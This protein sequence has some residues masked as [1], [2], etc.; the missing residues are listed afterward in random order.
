MHQPRFC[1]CSRRNRVTAACARTQRAK[2][3]RRFIVLFFAGA[4]LRIERSAP[5]WQTSTHPT[6]RPNYHHPRECVAH[7]NNQKARFPSLESHA[8]L[9]APLGRSEVRGR[10]NAEEMRKGCCIKSREIQICGTNY[11]PISGCLFMQITDSY[12]SLFAF[13]VSL[14]L[15]KASVSIQ[16]I[17]NNCEV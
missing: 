8:Q 3:S 1:L 2:F 4:P 11:R 5:S 13:G 17:L 12:V 14:L 16:L 6:N 9:K 15:V 10:E 7:E